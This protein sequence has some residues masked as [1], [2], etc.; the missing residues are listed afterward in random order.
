MAANCLSRSED[1]LH[2]INC[3]ATWLLVGL[4]SGIAAPANADPAPSE[5][6]T[7]DQCEAA[8]GQARALAL[9][10]PPDDLSRYF[11]ERHLHQALV[12]AGNGEYDDCLEA[13]ARATEELR[14]R[15]HALQPGERLKIL[16]PDEIPM[17]EPGDMPPAAGDRGR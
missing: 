13:A 16:Q 2:W 17:R 4:A 8:V 5:E 15:R 12:E 9:S 1:V 10:V 3:L 6:P 11:A 14:E 7:L